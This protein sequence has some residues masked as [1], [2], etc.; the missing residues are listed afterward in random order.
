M[1][2]KSSCLESQKRLL[3]VRCIT[4]PI[5]TYSRS[6]S[7]FNAFS[8]V[9]V[10]VDVK[11]PGGVNAYVV[12]LRGER[13][14]LVFVDAFRLTSTRHLATK[15]PRRYGRKHTSAPCSAPSSI[16]TT[17]PISS[18]HTANSTLYL[19]PRQRLGFCRLQRL[20][21]ARVC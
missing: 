10:R 11:I 5:C 4:S 15:Q 20:Y 1:V 6:H 14:A 21:S 13:Y 7:C 19:H 18:T 9:D 8:R 17:P 2:F 3:F 16:R 12:D